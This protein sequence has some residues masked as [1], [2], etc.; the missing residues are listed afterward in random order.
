MSRRKFLQQTS[1]LGAASFIGWGR[2]ALAEPPP[3][4]KKFA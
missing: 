1:A 2:P 3:E 4:V